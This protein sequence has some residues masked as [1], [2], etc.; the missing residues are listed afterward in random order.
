MK[1]DRKLLTGAAV[2]VLVLLLGTVASC[3]GMPENISAD[4]DCPL[5][6]TKGEEFTFEI[7]ITNTSSDTQLLYN[8]D[9]W[10]EYMESISII[11]T[12]PAFIDTYHIPI[13]NTQSFEFQKEIP[14]HGTLTL[15]FYA[16]GHQTG[17][18]SSY[19]DICIN[20]ASSFVSYPIITIV[21]D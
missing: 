1:I 13:D 3:V 11:E 17:E 4:I 9:I 12:E 2:L 6:V 19:L 20:S 21:D 14:P 8:I 15:N 7:R 16:V 10:D 18:Y 5:H